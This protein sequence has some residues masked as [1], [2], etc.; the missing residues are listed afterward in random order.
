MSTINVSIDICQSAGPPE[1]RTVTLQN[2]LQSEKIYF[3][4]NVIFHAAFK[5]YYP[6]WLLEARQQDK[7]LL[8]IP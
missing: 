2:V 1:I 8:A 6:E 3:Q 5:V 4:W 7:F